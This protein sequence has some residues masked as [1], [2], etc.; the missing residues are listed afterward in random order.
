MGKG[1]QKNDSFVSA[2]FS[3]PYVVAACL[4]DGEL[5]PLQLTEKRMADE[6][7]LEVTEKVHV[8]TDDVLNKRYPEQTSS[9]LEIC[10][11]DGRILEKQIDIPKGDPRDPMT[12][13]DLIS[14]IKKYAGHRSAERI[15]TVSSMVLELETVT[16][17][18][19]LIQ[20]I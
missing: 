19:K 7:L 4:A 2:Q 5:G 18:N 14:K 15:E 10:L 16:D 9:R 1:V 8:K 17:V 3:I 12:E 11:T 13:S 6:S 20:L